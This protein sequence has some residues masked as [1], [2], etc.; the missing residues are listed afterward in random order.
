[1][2]YSLMRI[3]PHHKPIKQRDAVNSQCRRQAG[4]QMSS[5]DFEE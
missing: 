4:D 3:C 5:Q 1:M 2:F